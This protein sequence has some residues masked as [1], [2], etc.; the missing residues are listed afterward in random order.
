MKILC[1]A[2]LSVLLFTFNAFSQVKTEE[3][4]AAPKA[5]IVKISL[6][7]LPGV[8]D[9][10]SKWEFSY[11]LRLITEKEMNEAARTGKLKQMDDEEKLGVLVGQGNFTKNALSKNENREVTLNIPLTE[12]IQARLKKQPKN[13]AKLSASAPDEKT[14]ES[15]KNSQ[16]EAQVFL[17]YASALVYDAKLKKNLLI[18]MSWIMPFYRHPDANFA[19]VF[20]IAEDGGINRR[21][22]IPE[23][24]KSSITVTTKQ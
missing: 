14:I 6:L 1:V 5:A 9:E 2:F 20:E 10:K 24:S 19:M 12:E 3:A 21:I 7:D 18:P 15:I 22:I 4:E 11:Q 13:R 23:N 16:S 17:L 8:K